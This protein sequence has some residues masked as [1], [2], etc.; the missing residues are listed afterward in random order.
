V[1][2][3]SATSSTTSSLTG[4]RRRD[5]ARS[6]KL[7]GQF[8]GEENYSG[9]LQNTRSS[10]ANPHRRGARAHAVG[11]LDRGHREPGF[12]KVEFYSEAGAEYGSPAFLGEEQVII[13]D[14][15]SPEDTWTPSEL[16]GVAP[17][18]RSRRASR[19][20]SASRRRTRV[21]RS[22]STA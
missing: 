7:F 21:A 18:M 15:F 11:R 12:L 19:S 9:V 8:N 2:R 16:S 22:S 1:A 4:A 20:S 5:G 17:A 13:A 10:A 14:G 3:V 6:L